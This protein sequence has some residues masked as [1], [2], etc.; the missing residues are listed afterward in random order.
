[1]LTIIGSL[2]DSVNSVPG[3]IWSRLVGTAPLFAANALRASAR[4]LA[5]S[6][7][8]RTKLPSGDAA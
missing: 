8:S 1:M 6:S 2:E 5:G 3:T 4:K 7:V